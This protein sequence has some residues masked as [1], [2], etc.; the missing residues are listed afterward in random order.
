MLLASL[1]SRYNEMAH[2]SC[3]LLM[4]SDPCCVTSLLS[5]C[6]VAAP[7]ASGAFLLLY[8]GLV[9]T[10]FLLAVYMSTSPGYRHIINV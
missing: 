5:S 2:I 7:E 1:F 9:P 8:F 4:L 10:M 3:E 6:Y